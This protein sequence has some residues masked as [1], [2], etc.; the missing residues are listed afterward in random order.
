MCDEIGD[1][2]LGRGDK[3]HSIWDKEHGMWDKF[4]KH[5]PMAIHFLNPIK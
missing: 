1:I 3:E 5:W 2:E 4:G